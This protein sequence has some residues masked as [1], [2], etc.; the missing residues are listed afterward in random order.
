MLPNGAVIRPI[1]RTHSP[2][3]L[4]G[5]LLAT[6]LFLVVTST[7]IGKAVRDALFLSHFTTLQMTYAD[8]HT[9]IA[10]AVTIG[11][12][13]R[14]HRSRTLHRMLISSSVLFAIGDAACWCASTV[15][16][17]WVTRGI[18]CWIGTQAAISLP[19]VSM[20][21]RQVLTTRQAKRASALIGT[22]AIFG[23]IVGGLVTSA[24][25]RFGTETLLLVMA[26][27]TAASP[28]LVACLRRTGET[29]AN[30]LYEADQTLPPING[31]LRSA[32]LVSGCPHL[33]T[34]A[35]LVFLSSVVTT[36]AGLQFKAIASQ[37]FGDTDTFTAFLG[38]FGLYA[39]LVSL[40]IQMLLTSRILRYAGVGIALVIAPLALAAG[41]VGVLIY[42]SL[43]AAAFL[44]GSDHVLRHSIDRAAL[45]L[46]YVPLSPD[47]TLQAKTFIEAVV[48][49]IGDGVGALVVAF[50]A[51]VLH[52]TFPSLSVI[53]LGFL[54][55]WTGVAIRAPHGYVQRLL[56]TLRP[57]NE[58]AEHERACDTTVAASPATRR[59]SPVRVDVPDSAPLVV[60]VGPPDD[61]RRL[62][63]SVFESN[64]STRLEN[65]RALNAFQASH[66]HV[67][68]EA[69]LLLTA[70]AAEIVGLYRLL[71]T[72]VQTRSDE[73]TT[74]DYEQSL[75]RICQLLQLISPEHD[76]FSAFRAIRSGDPR[77][78]ANALEYLEN[79]L[80]PG[81][82]ALLVSL[83]ELETSLETD[84]RYCSPAP[85]PVV[86]DS[87]RG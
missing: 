29:S 49:R 34:V 77:L 70:L 8:L 5:V 28:A 76:S 20:L 55:A 11:V 12:Y 26:A 30:H 38:S 46:L 65:L 39:G 23:W 63:E 48:Y 82:R 36:I 10:I 86:Q 15:H 52:L 40:A 7:V 14:L 57:R 17:G 85:S 19:Q 78:K 6:Y 87:G 22:G 61:G 71:E 21:V 16:E 37:S 75:E 44:K 33:R 43:A 80:K 4:Q 72:S 56:V 69:G 35:S 79:V 32:A 9:L 84:R 24:A 3:L 81:Y 45:E 83:L 27:L 59:Q 41:S 67:L 51:T 74:G 58:V 47:E 18:Y 73:S 53:S 64:P 68:A 42:G 50:G 1:T 25:G 62:V 60:H 2:E 13:F 54:A 66:P 31:L